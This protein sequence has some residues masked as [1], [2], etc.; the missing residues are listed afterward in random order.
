MKIYTAI[1]QLETSLHNEAAAFRS[2]SA[3]GDVTLAIIH[4]N[5]AASVHARLA[6]L[7]SWSKAGKIWSQ[8]F[9]EEYLPKDQ[10]G[11]NV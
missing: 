10:Q 11:V 8:A 4:M 3:M 1:E 2:A 5:T 7:I 6:E 9:S